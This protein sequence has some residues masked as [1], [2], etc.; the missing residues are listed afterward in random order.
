MNMFAVFLCVLCSLGHWEPY[1]AVYHLPFIATNYH[2]L[3]IVII[4]R[5]QSHGCV[6]TPPCLPPPPPPPHTHT[7]PTHF[8]T[9]H[10]GRCV[11]SKTFR[12][13]FVN[14]VGVEQQLKVRY[15][16]L[17]SVERK[18]HNISWEENCSKVLSVTS[19]Q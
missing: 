18:N 7:F 2:L 16:L 15:G 19:Y 12:S 5:R 9:S 17:S 6:L 1:L 14:S 3:P 13:N 10:L 11:L 4:L 8:N